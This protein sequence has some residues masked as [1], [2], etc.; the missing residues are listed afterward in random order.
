MISML[1]GYFIVWNVGQG[2][3]T[4][5]I[6]QN[7]CSHFDAGGETDI[8]RKLKPLCYGK[9][10]LI[11]LSHW[12]MDH[13]SFVSGFQKRH[14]RYCVIPPKHLPKKKIAQNLFRKIKICLPGLKSSTELRLIYSGSDGKKAKS[15]DQSMVYQIKDILIP[16]DSTTTQELEWAKKTT[17]VKHLVLGHHGSRSST[18]DFLLDNLSS[19]KMAI[20][21]ARKAKYKHPH[22]KVVQRL[23][24]KKIPQLNTEDW[25]SI[26][27]QTQ[28]QPP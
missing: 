12:D 8:F 7:H 3:F 2:Q 5:F 13:I 23:R 14:F 21:S 6:E 22:P 16:G 10:N 24:S 15:N 25:G 18:S 27:I 17:Q 20:C 26:G 19:L 11:Y 1:V 4:S 9:M 28:T